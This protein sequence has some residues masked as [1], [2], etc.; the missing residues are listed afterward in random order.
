MAGKHGAQMLLLFIAAFGMVLSTATNRC[1]LAFDSNVVG[2]AATTRIGDSGH[3][4][5]TL[6]NVSDRVVT[7]YK[8]RWSKGLFT[9]HSTDVISALMPSADPRRQLRAGSS[10]SLDDP[11]GP[12]TRP[13]DTA[14][15]G[16]VYADNSWE[17]EP[18]FAQT[19]FTARR[20]HAAA[21]EQ[22]VLPTLMSGADED[23]ARMAGQM[24]TAALRARQSRELDE[25]SGA[26]YLEAVADR[27]DH[28]RNLAPDSAKKALGAIVSEENMMLQ[29]LKAHMHP[30]K[31][32]L[33]GNGR[34]QD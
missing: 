30:A 20:Q 33:G 18:G 2:L 17:G 34:P 10:V 21:I 25:L 9:E 28:A 29:T 31:A 16:V 6:R 32:I 15:V 8:L 24:R 7:A 14:V 27:L 13:V 3:L 4:Q 1:V 19:I 11:F 26:Q 5:L 23:V 12:S 22:M